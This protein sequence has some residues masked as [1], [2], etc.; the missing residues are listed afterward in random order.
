MLTGDKE[1]GVENIK[2]MPNLTWLFYLCLLYP[3]YTWL[4][5]LMN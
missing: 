5:I 2:A 3:V 4:A 1:K